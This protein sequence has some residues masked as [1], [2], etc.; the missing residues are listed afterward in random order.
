MLKKCLV[1]MSLLFFIF[2]CTIPSVNNSNPAVYSGQVKFQLTGVSEKSNLSKTG[3]ISGVNKSQTPIT[4]A[5]A[6]LISVA[7]MNGN[8]ILDTKKLSLYNMSGG[9]IS[10]PLPLNT[11][12]YQLTKFMVINSSNTVIY[13]TPYGGSPLAYLVTNPLPIGF[14]IQKD[15]V[16]TLS[17][18][19]IDVT[20]NTAQDFGYATFSFKIVNTFGFMVAVSV[21]VNGNFELAS[22]NILIKSASEILYSNSIGAKTSIIQLK[23][24]SSDYNITISKDGYQDYNATFSN[25]H[26]KDYSSSPLSVNLTKSV[27]ETITILHTNDIHAAIDSFPKLAAKVNEIRNAAAANETV[28][29][30]SAGDN[31]SGNPI[32]DQYDPKGYPVIE[33]MKMTGYDIATIGNH[34][35]DYGQSVLN[36][37]I[38]Q[39]GFPYVSANIKAGTGSVLIQPEPYKLLT[40]KMN[41]KVAFLGLIQTEANNYPSSNIG[42]LTGLTF[43]NAG[44]EALNYKNLK[45]I[46]GASV[47]ILLSHLGF[48]TDQTLAGSMNEIDAIVGAHSHTTVS[49]PQSTNGV[50]ITQAGSGLAYLGKITVKL[51]DGKVT[52]KSGSLI[53]ISGLTAED[54]GVKAKVAEFN[55]N[56]IFDEIIGTASAKISGKDELGSFMTDS[57]VSEHGLDMYFQNN[58]GIRISSI[59]QGNITKRTVYTLD[60]FGN[61]VVKFNLTTTQI[62]SLIAYS[63]RK[64]NSIDLQVSG[65]KYS[66]K[67]DAAKNIQSITLKDY[68]DVPIDESKTYSV[69]MNDYIASSYDFDGKG[70]G[71]STYV[72]SADT[73]INYVKKHTPIA[74][75]KGTVRASE[76]IIPQKIGTTAVTISNGSDVYNSTSTAGN[77]MADAIKDQTGADI[78]TFTSSNLNAS[79]SI[80]AGDLSDKDLLSL[81]KTY[82]GTDYAVVGSISGA[83]LKQF[84]LTRS[85]KYNNADIQVSGMKY[86]IVKTGSTV[87]SVECFLADGTTPIK[88]TMTYKVSFCSYNYNLAS[89]SGAYLLTGKVANTVTSTMTEQDMILAYINKI[90][91]VTSAISDTRITF[92]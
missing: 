70:G 47:F 86:N 50:L 56:P 81:Y 77:L 46:T 65:I 53:G 7:D 31:F 35:L 4:D 33:L 89:G 51:K 61:L 10:E 25:S 29:L 38:A 19:I 16:T 62:R 67:V 37:R 14:D 8:V 75:Y 59:P 5:S 69:G 11:G 2:S 40:T 22:A 44:T 23:D 43:P 76:E 36:D 21:P 85:Q 64:N 24:V 12:K 79:K 66:V 39:G 74:S 72:T 54:A 92:K 49:N 87:T 68:N 15:K 80:A 52:E 34:D 78:A 83:D 63:Y 3:S 20:G 6:I 45:N 9:F 17:P 30:V 13:A 55:N 48:D 26:M 57:A 32:V 84:V 58:G 82:I 28:F 42:N 91:N 73:L 90:K 88:D 60:P 41:T 18:E 27:E 71:V 1:L